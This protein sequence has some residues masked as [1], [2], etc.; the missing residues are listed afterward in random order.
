ALDVDP[1]HLAR[2]VVEV[3]THLRAWIAPGLIEEDAVLPDGGEAEVGRIAAHG[4]DPRSRRQERRRGIDPVGAAPGVLAE[5]ALDHRELGPEILAREQPARLLSGPADVVDAV[6][7][8]VVEERRR[9]RASRAGE[10]TG[11]HER[12]RG[13]ATERSGT[14]RRHPAYDTLT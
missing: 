14:G 13:P 12:Q 6:E 11:Q 1:S 9:A 5:R 4:V 3:G 2:D 8:D 10:E 7:G